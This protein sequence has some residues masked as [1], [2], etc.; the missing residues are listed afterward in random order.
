MCDPVAECVRRGRWATSS[1]SASVRVAPPTRSHCLARA[2]GKFGGML[3]TVPAR[4]LPG[5]STRV[6]EVACHRPKKS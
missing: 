5:C 6:F 3:E 1:K 2:L 4:S